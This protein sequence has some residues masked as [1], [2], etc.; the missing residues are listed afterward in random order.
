ML[1][2]KFGDALIEE[3]DRKETNKFVQPRSTLTV[4]QKFHCLEKLLR[5]LDEELETVRDTCN[6]IATMQ[7]SMTKVVDQRM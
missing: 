7:S 6:E 2:A 1:S 4:E 5:E 3:L